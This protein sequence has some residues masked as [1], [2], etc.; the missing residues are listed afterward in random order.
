MSDVL[1]AGRMNCPDKRKLSI[2][3]AFGAWM[4]RFNGEPPYIYWRQF[5]ATQA[6]RIRQ[7][8]HVAFAAGWKAMMDRLEMEG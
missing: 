8:L 3:S 2:E 7:A 1:S 6:H 4:D 5:D